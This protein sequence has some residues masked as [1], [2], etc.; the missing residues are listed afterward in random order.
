E[1]LSFTQS[2]FGLNEGKQPDEETNRETV[3][4][5]ATT[6]FNE[7][8]SNGDGLVTLEDMVQFF[9]RYHR[10]SGN[11]NSS[12]DNRPNSEREATTI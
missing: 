2:V 3:Q 12:I 9:K 6:I 7:L 11:K 5:R 10:A 1:F 4:Q 8:D